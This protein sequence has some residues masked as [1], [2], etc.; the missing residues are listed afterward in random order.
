MAAALLYF[1]GSFVVTLA[2]NVPRNERLARLDAESEEAATYW[3]LYAR[4]WTRWNH[5]RA[6]ASA[7]AAA[8][9]AAA[10]AN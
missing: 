1:A 6:I 9:S 5:V 7:S 8:C 2:F 3:Q 4:D 10:L